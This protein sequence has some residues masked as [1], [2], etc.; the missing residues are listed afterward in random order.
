MNEGEGV[1]GDEKQ[2]SDIQIEGNFEQDKE[3]QKKEEV[4]Q[5]PVIKAASS[6]PRE[7]LKDILTK[8]K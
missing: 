4:V 8:L 1:L 7:P 5:K 3:N 6:T 2:S